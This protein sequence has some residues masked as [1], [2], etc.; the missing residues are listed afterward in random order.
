MSKCACGSG[1]PVKTVIKA[2]K[3]IIGCDK[4]LTYAKSANVA[5]YERRWQRGQY[6]KD[7]TQS[8]D[9]KNFTRAYPDRAKE[10]YDEA[11]LRRWS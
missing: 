6:R 2:G 11:T 5:Q 4:C 10:L 1:L 7:I 3:I 9:P 8:T